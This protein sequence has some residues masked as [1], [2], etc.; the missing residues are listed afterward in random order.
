MEIH[1]KIVSTVRRAVRNC[2]KQGDENVVKSIKWQARGD[3]NPRPLPCQPTSDRKENNLES[4]E[5]PLYNRYTRF[6]GKN[7]R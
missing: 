7:H 1:I 5:H 2:K 4:I 3:S 6:T